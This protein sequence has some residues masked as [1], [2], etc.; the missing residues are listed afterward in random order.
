[1]N[2]L[3]PRQCRHPQPGHTPSPECLGAIA[4]AELDLHYLAEGAANVIY[5]VS[6]LPSPS[7]A[8]QEHSHCCVMRLRKDVPSTKPIVQVVSDFKNRTSPLFRHVD[9]DTDTDD[10]ENAS[11]LLLTQKLYKLTPSMVE[12]LNVEL[13]EM[14]ED[15]LPG[16]SFPDT[17]T[18]RR[19]PPRPHH[20]RN[21]YLP[22]YEQEQYGVLMQNLQGPGVDWLIEFKPKWLV[23][24]PSAPGNAKTCRTCALNAMRRSSNE[25]H[26]GR[27]D[28]GFCPL[29]LLEQGGDELD[30]ALT[31]IWPSDLDQD[32]L[33]GFV[34]QFK[35][36]V[37]PALYH[38]RRLQR[39]HGAVGID[40]FRKRSVAEAETENLG[41]A[42]ALR[43]CSCFVA[44]KKRR[45]GHDIGGDDDGVDIID[46]KFADLDLKTTKG[47]KL[48]K[49]AAMEQDLLDGGWYTRSDLGCLLSRSHKS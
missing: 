2:G 14:E 40:D 4:N 47:G 28:S 37:Q 39:E 32:G 16:S 44:L 5:S 33:P 25:S 18:D 42:M 45:V 7:S 34:A 41:V 1:M 6:V 49:W 11:S 43:D 29:D 8:L 15:T 36:R 9:T 13:H 21:K 26:Q 24:S 31:K 27:G 20:R 19:L 23:Q 22:S 17:R 12:S 10:T 35:E 48:E 46:V 3:H 38:L 30:R